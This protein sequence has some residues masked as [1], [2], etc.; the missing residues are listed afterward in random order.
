MHKKTWVRFPT[1]HVVG[2]VMMQPVTSVL[3][4]WSQEED[5]KFIPRL[6]KEFKTSTGCARPCSHKQTKF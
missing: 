3:R 6:H 4:R 5:Q 2:L 1:L